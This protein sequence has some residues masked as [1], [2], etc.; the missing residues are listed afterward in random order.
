VKYDELMNA[1]KIRKQKVS[2]DE[3]RRAMERASRDLKTAQ[4]IMGEDWDWGFAVAYNAILQASRAYMFANGYRPSGSEVHKNTFAFMSI[5]MGKEY[6]DL[7]I[8][9]DLMRSKR[10][11]AI[12]DVAGVITEAEAR[13][14]LKKAMEYVELIRELLKN[15][16]K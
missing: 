6:K 11:R 4:K 5:A 2:S 12:Y 9:V 13:N 16:I 1:G 10:N 8:F 14:L 7:F 15:K 3:V